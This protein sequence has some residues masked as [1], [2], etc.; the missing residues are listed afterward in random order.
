MQRLRFKCKIK[1]E[2]NG[3][4]EYLV[5]VVAAAGLGVVSD[6]ICTSYGKSSKGVEKFVKLAV[7]LCMLGFIIIPAIRSADY[8]EL[9]GSLEVTE[10]S[11]KVNEDDVLYKL[12]YECEQ[13]AAE[14]IFE[15]TGIK[16]IK[17]VIDIK[18][19]GQAPY[20]DEAEIILEAKYKEQDDAV[21]QAAL[22]ALGVEVN[23]VYE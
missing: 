10:A 14:Y 11:G 13:R 8:A 2:L 3:V 7:T 6:I 20:I 17:A 4:N 21:R 12:E 5:S 18:S 16:P 19:E 15:K 22:E 9:I 23:V 1:G